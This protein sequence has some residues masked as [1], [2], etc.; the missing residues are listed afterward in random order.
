L[1]SHGELGALRQWRLHCLLLLLLNFLI[2]CVPLAAAR[3]CAV[4]F[5]TTAALSV[6]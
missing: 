5:L 3:A 1:L 6:F 2:V 4:V